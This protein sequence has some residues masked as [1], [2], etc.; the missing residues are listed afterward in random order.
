MGLHLRPAA[1]TATP[2]L[3]SSSLPSSLRAPADALLTE[4][5]SAATPQRLRDEFTMA[6]G[7]D[8]VRAAVLQALLQQLDPTA[9]KAPAF[10]AIAVRAASVRSTDPA[11]KAARDLVQSRLIDQPAAVE[12]L[13]GIKQ[14]LDN[15]L[16]TDGVV[17]LVF[18]GPTGTGKSMGVGV[19]AELLHGDARKKIE[20]SFDTKKDAAQDASAI[21]GAGAGYVGYGDKT[22]LSKA[23]IQEVFGDSEPI[24]I[25]LD[26]IDKAPRPVRDELL[27]MFS[28]FIE[29][30]TFELRN[31]ERPFER[32][33]GSARRVVLTMTTNIGTETSTGLRDDALAKHFHQAF[34]AE[35]SGS[36]LDYLMGRLT[37]G[38]IVPF[39]EL[40]SSAM[41]KIA[42]IELNGLAR[43]VTDALRVADDIDLRLSIDPAVTTLLG[44][45]GHQP[46]FGARPLKGIITA[47]V[48]PSY[49]AVKR[50]A[51]D[52]DAWQLRIAHDA[53]AADLRGVHAAFSNAA[54]GEIPV[55][56]E[57]PLEF[58]RTSTAPTFQPWAGAGAFVGGADAVVHASGVVG[59]K[60]FVVLTGS[61]GEHELGFLK[62]G[63]TQ[64]KDA[65]VTVTLPAALAQANSMTP[66]VAAALDD[67]HLLLVATHYPDDDHATDGVST[68][69]VYD[70]TT[71]RFEAVKPPPV[72]LQGA[73]LAGV[74][75]VGV[76]F[77]GRRAERDDSGAWSIPVEA[78]PVDL[79][80]LDVERAGYRFDLTSRAWQVLPDWPSAGR[81]GA[82][83][84]AREG[85]LWFI[86]GEETFATS[87]GSH[88]LS[89]SRA[90]TAV[91]VYDPA[92]NTVTAST[93]LA[94]PVVFAQA[95][96]DSAGRLVVLG[97]YDVADGGRT[98][99]PRTGM[100]RFNPGL[101]Q[102]RW[103]DVGVLPAG[104]A[105]AQLALVAHP[106]GLVV[107][108]LADAAGF[109][110]LSRDGG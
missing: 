30:G 22:V 78:T 103:K 42:A 70:V 89:Q 74:G 98:W 18:V 101:A 20:I 53:T 23:R 93:R 33:D 36:G 91:D 49:A 46:Q 26:D 15:G 43:K 84:V 99:T 88:Q 13:L 21:T 25:N 38:A 75:G 102:A 35:M 97:G 19:L 12:A 104:A 72:A 76:L 94:S 106:D 4:L 27:K 86:G 109:S 40:S 51:Q 11:M 56:V 41:T 108:P 100:E 66:L 68:A 6:S 5:G 32:A 90:S 29:T 48:E 110:I 7:R 52:E 87:E 45:L 63:A 44:E 80:G 10:N 79:M 85:K 47:L 92:T 1:S 3:S 31:G 62:P 57:L 67:R 83:A 8:P 61:S 95:Y 96:A 50:S 107:G 73:S 2:V 69:F 65:L 82:A 9:P 16:W 59:G 14:R 55:G 28:R 105:G 39:G 58:V 77:G 81:M 24:I 71:K 54:P 34:R 17:P 60:S 64:A 37:Q